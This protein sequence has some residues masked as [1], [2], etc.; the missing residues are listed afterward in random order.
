MTIAEK[1]TPAAWANWKSD[2]TSYVPYRTQE[3]AARCVERSSI[4]ATQEG[5]YYVRPLYDAPAPQMLKALEES[6]DLVPRI[7]DDDPMAPALAEWCRGVRALL[8]SM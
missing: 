4:V 7:S 8:E 5:P 6:L 1:I 3:E 2:S